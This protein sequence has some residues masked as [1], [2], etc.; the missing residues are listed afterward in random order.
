[1]T[2][3]RRGGDPDVPA[4][5]LLLDRTAWWP[6]AAELA[7]DCT[8]I[9]VD[10]PGHGESP[11]RHSYEPDTL[12]EE[13]GELLHRLGTRRAPLVVGHADSTLLAAKF[14]AAFATR[15]IV[16]VQQ[17]LDL[18]PL[19]ARK[20]G[21]RSPRP[22]NGEYQPVPPVLGHQADRRPCGQAPAVTPAMAA[23]K[24]CVP[25]AEE[26]FAPVSVRSARFGGLDQRPVL[27]DILTGMCCQAQS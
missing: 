8:V 23:I 15:A 14:G 4:A 6:V 22:V 19:I 25:R 27:A 7:T 26:R 11:S 16:N 24:P 12:V 13:L 3:A 18:Q 17:P 9:A 1:M 5:A 20:R 21:P 2:A 10:L